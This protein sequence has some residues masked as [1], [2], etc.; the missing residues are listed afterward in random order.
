MHFCVCVSVNMC[1]QTCVFT[2]CQLHRR[3]VKISC[4]CD[5]GDKF[6]FLFKLASS[7]ISTPVNISPWYHPTDYADYS[8]TSPTVSGV[9]LW[10]ITRPDAEV[11]DA[12]ATSH[13]YCDKHT[14]CTTPDTSNFYIAPIKTVWAM[15]YRHTVYSRWN[16]NVIMIII[17]YLKQ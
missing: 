2:L 13:T 3:D 6:S 11:T 12:R 5:G 4:K 1:A 10:I 15:F 9:H 14:V 16:E 8:L 17:W 7:Y